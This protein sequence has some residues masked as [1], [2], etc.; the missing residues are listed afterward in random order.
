MAAQQAVLSRRTGMDGQD[1]KAFPVPHAVLGLN[2]LR[3]ARVG[4]TQN[5][6]L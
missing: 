1:A 6:D 3:T 5:V 2:S 4:Q